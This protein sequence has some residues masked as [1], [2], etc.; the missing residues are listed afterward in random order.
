MSE[1]LPVVT[2]GE[3]LRA[4]ERAG[5]EKRRARGSH[6]QVI[7]FYP[8]GSASTFPIPLHGKK[9]IPTGTLRSILRQ[10]G[11]TAEDLRELL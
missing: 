8:D 4:L 6:V 3:L 7:K 11:L 2:G 10:A 9:A 5:Y 1:K